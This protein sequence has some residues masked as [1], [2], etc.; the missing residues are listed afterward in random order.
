MQTNIRRGRSLIAPDGE[1]ALRL[2]SRNGHREIV[3]YLPSRR[4]GGFRR[5]K[6]KHQ[7]AVRRVKK[8]AGK[9]RWFFELAL[10]KLPLCFLW[11]IPKNV[12]VEPLIKEVKWLVKNYKRLPQAMLASLKKMWVKLK[13]F[14]K[15]V[16]RKLWGTIKGLPNATKFA[17]VW[18]WNGI[19][20]AG[21]AVLHIITRFFA[22][23]HTAITAIA[24]FFRTITLKDI[25]YGFVA[26]VRAVFIEGPKKIW[27]WLCKF[28]DMMEKV[29]ETL[30]GCTGQ[31][32][33]WIIVGLATFVCM[34]PKGILDILV[35][36]GGSIAKGFEEVMIWFNP[37][38]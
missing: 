37:K 2:A 3:D 16:G 34:V 29:F 1:L 35:A 30:W 38:R 4:G 12:I 9:I 27:K 19:K 32:L 36:I 7:K 25:W 33:W 8:A 11:H 18:V 24:E 20:S 22:F 15:Y 14:G 31:V 5:W 6:T 23:I 17:L 13:K 26:L 28:G 10:Y 21:D